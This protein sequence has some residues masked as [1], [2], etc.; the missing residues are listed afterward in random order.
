M[1]GLSGGIRLSAG[2]TALALTIAALSAAAPP[3]AADTCGA[4]T[5]LHQCSGDPPKASFEISPSA[6]HRREQVTFT[7][8]A[9]ANP[10]RTVKSTRWD[11]Y[12]DDEFSD[13]TTLTAHRTFYAPGTYTIRLRVED[14]HGATTVATGPVTVT[15][16]PAPGPAR[17]RQSVVFQANAM[18]DGFISARAPAPPLK[19]LWSRKLGAKVS[20]A[21]M[22]PTGRIFV[23]A[24]SSST[25]GAR[26]YALD[27]RSGAVAWSRVVGEHGFPEP[28]QLAYDKGRLFAVGSGGLILALDTRSGRTLWAVQQPNDSAPAAPL[29]HD[30]IVWTGASGVGGTEYAFRES[31]GRF[32]W[33]QALFSSA[34]PPAIDANNLYVDDPCD[35]I[36]GMDA[37]SG[38]PQWWYHGDCGGG[39]GGTVP[40]VHQGNVWGLGTTSGARDGGWVVRAVDGVLVKRFRA[41]QPPAFKG[42]VGVFLRGTVLS[43]KNLKSGSQLWRFKG[44]GKLATPPF[45]VGQV[46]Y[47]GSRSGRVYAVRLRSGRR[48]WTGST[49]RRDA[50]V[51]VAGLAA[52]GGTLVV[53]SDGRVTAF[54]SRHQRRVRHRHDHRG[55]PVA[56]VPRARARGGRSV[57]QQVNVRHD[58]FLNV[59]SPAPPLRRVWAHSRDGNAGT[60]VVAGGMAFDVDTGGDSVRAY[61]LGSGKQVWA[62]RTGRDAEGHGGA[63]GAAYDANTLFVAASAGLIA[64]RASDGKELWRHTPSGAAPVASGGLV[65]L[66][67]D[68]EITA[69][70]QSDG[71]FAWRHPVLGGDTSVPALAAGR[72][73]VSYACLNASAY[74]RQ[75][76]DPAWAI[77]PIG[78]TGGGGASPAFHNGRVY[79]REGSAAF[80]LDPRSGAILDSFSADAP[81]AFAGNAA[82]VLSGTT[83]Q[84]I[85]LRTDAPIWTFRP[86]H[87]ELRTAPLIVGRTVYVGARDGTLY[88]L[89]LGSGRVAWR[90]HVGEPFLPD[91]STSADEN[92]GFAAGG[93]HLVVATARGLVAFASKHGR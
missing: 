32:L 3:A 42:D 56:G 65:Y 17:P 79:V 36:Y 46:A 73:Y 87:D 34:G 24:S 11:L 75:S 26:V 50:Q 69:V 44:D 67:S 38:Y 27:R 88:G 76:G 77:H 13:G 92:H 70:R 14:D 78:C 61:R 47:V 91:E 39:P 48:A 64:Y 7:G 2:A 28:A 53:P 12:H 54:G 63:S 31:D 35:G 23:S 60:P 40:V 90:T 6:P 89:R 4:P 18:R 21:V 86:R 9:S 84:A 8:S 74:D 71:T 57:T 30:G 37:L 1:G 82:I 85:D 58:G 5:N 20:Y 68:G 22:S 81:P 55:G 59:R 33:Q 15:D 62:R 41:T 19:K 72:A 93:G 43:A 45:I 80:A 10:D 52:G 83:L 16:P 25:S 66:S 49:A 29:A 51:A